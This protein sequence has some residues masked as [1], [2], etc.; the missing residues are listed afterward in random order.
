MK[1][2]REIASLLDDTIE[3]SSLVE[4]QEVAKAKA[5]RTEIRK[6]LSFDPMSPIEIGQESTIHNPY[7]LLP[8]GSYAPYSAQHWADQGKYDLSAAGVQYHRMAR[9]PDG[10]RESETMLSTMKAVID[11][12]IVKA[13][14]R[15]RPTP[16]SSGQPRA[17]T[18]PIGTVHEYNGEPFRKEGPGDWQP[19][20]SGAGSHPVEQDYLGKRKGIEKELAARQNGKKVSPVAERTKQANEKLSAV[21]QRE[22]DLST[23][24]AEVS[25]R[26]VE[27]RHRELDLREAQLKAKEDESNRVKKEED[28]SKKAAKAKED[29]SKKASMKNGLPTEGIYEPK[30]SLGIKR[31]EMPQVSSGDMPEFLNFLADRGVKFSSGDVKVKNYKSS[32]AEVNASAAAKLTGANLQKSIIVSND[33]YVID[34]H[35]R[36]YGKLISGEKFASA[37]KIDMKAKDL[38]DVMKE[39]G[40]VGMTDIHGKTKATDLVFKRGGKYIGERRKIHERILNDIV[41]DVKPIPPPEGHRPVAVFTAG[42]PGSGKSSMVKAAHE[43]F[44]KDMAQIAADE[45]KKEIPEYSKELSRGNEDAAI[46]VH[47]ESTDIAAEAIQRCIESGKPFLLDSTFKNVPKFQNMIKELKDKGYDI[48]VLYA[49]CPEDEAV[50]RAKQRQED[51]GRKV[52]EKVVREGNHQ[53]KQALYELGGLADTTSVFDTTA[54]GAPPPELMFHHAASKKEDFGRV[55]DIVKGEEVKGEKKLYDRFLD[56]I[57]SGKYEIEH[58]DDNSEI[59]F[60]ERLKYEGDEA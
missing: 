14:P 60:G 18:V 36:W 31:S 24:E 57:K 39:F 15:G 38:F 51:T 3:K 11:D 10:Y 13:I 53:A 2:I 23:K 25:Q 22:Q 35:H 46:L 32:Q 5:K 27:H 29:E 42:G 34:G 30:D 9:N 50:R 21:T 59:P 4:R 47:E 16:A 20:R 56:E 48:H 26:E 17:G 7:R 8:D 19:V 41:G 43:K 37:V 40:K 6:A 45:V 54:K 58:D 44:G 55:R 12:S 33:G 1:D 52:D 49:H 28:E